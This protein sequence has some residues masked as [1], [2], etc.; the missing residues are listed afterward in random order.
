MPY[1][2][3]TDFAMPSFSTYRSILKDLQNLGLQAG[4]SVFVHASMTSVGTT[5]G[6]SRTVVQ[7]LLDQVGESGLVAMPGFSTD[8]CFPANF[9]TEGVDTAQIERIQ[10]SV[11]GFDPAKSSAWEMG[12]IAETFRTWPG[13]LR[14]NHPTTSVC[15]RGLNAKDIVADHSLAWAMGDATPFGKFYKRG[16]SKILLIGV[17]WNRCTALHT[18]ESFADVKRQKTRHFKNGGINGNWMTTPDV[19]DDLGRLF[20]SVGEAFEATGNVTTGM[21]GNAYCKLCGFRELVDY[22]SN[23]ISRANVRSGDRA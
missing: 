22:A 11:L 13:T 1:G 10:K 19:A 20:P 21:L 9:A 5:I 14:S 15:A 4:E 7:V 16:N 17:G 23:W 2:V 3:D 18:A 6:G 12:A 8:A